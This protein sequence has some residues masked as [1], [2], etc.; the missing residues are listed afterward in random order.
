MLKSWEKRGKRELARILARGFKARGAPG[1]IPDAASLQSILLIRTQNQLG[2]MLLATPALRALRE[3]APHARIDLVA[4]PANAE[5]VNGSAR[6]DQ[7]MVFE[8]QS[9]KR[10]GAG[11]TEWLRRLREGKYE[12][13]IVLSTVDFSTSAVSLAA[14]SG[15]KLRAGRAGK[16][17][18][19]LGAAQ[20]LFHW[21]LPPAVPGR[22]Q[23]DVNL[24]LVACFGAESR[25]GAP[26]IFLTSEEMRRGSHALAETLGERRADSLRIVIHPGAGKP[27]NRWPAEQFGRLAAELTLQGWRVCAAAGPREKELLNR[28][29]AGAGSSLPRLA[30]LEVREL[31]GALANADL[32]IANDT[33]ILHAGA[34]SGTR[35]LALFGPTDPKQ[36]CPAAPNVWYVEAPRGSLPDLSTQIVRRCAGFLADGCSGE[37]PAELHPA[38]SLS[39]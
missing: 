33:G 20:D 24:D 32:L 9:W 1:S 31:T 19:E 8:R 16:H 22:H 27:A 3:R 4:S 5:A 7:V 36:W 28:M 38:P 12:L 14:L 11:W 18:H 37:M 30:P 6:L 21:V 25:N 17:A 15:A 2:D 13:A 29:D 26:E 23:T 39:R 34:A 35:V 10:G